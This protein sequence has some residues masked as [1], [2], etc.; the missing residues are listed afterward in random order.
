[1][2][3][4]RSSIEIDNEILT[5]ITSVFLG[6]GKIM[7]NGCRSEKIRDEKLPS[8]TRTITETMK[9]GYIDREQLSFIYS[10]SCAMRNIPSSEIIAGLSAESANAVHTCNSSFGH[11]YSPLYH[12]I[13]VSR[14]N[15]K[16][17]KSELIKAQYVMANLDKHM[18][19]INKSLCDSVHAVLDAGHNKIESLH[20]N[21]DARV[22]ETSVDQALQFLRAIKF[23]CEIDR[24]SEQVNSISQEV[25]EFLQHAREI[26]RHLSLNSK[27]FP[28][29]LPE[30]FNTVICPKDGTKLTLPIES[31]DLIVICPT[32]KYR[33]A[34]NTSTVSFPENPE[35]QKLSLWKKFQNI[36]RQ[37]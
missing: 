17:F 10:V 18:T 21:A 30:M 5:D 12:Q 29:P 1:M 26:G 28:P 14:K 34:Y 24:Q 8:G 2:N 6:F 25:N 36:I 35:T 19:Y 4:I 22:N 27:Y 23:K 3:G 16:W 31:G 13:D 7:I 20:Q 9:V 15:V 37:K 32:C 11:H 33:F